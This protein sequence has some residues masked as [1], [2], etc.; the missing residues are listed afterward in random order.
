MKERILKYLDEFSRGVE[1]DLAEELMQEL[2]LDENTFRERSHRVQLEILHN[3]NQFSI[4]TIDAFFQRVIRSFTREAGLA[5]DYRLEV[6]QDDVLTAVINNLIDELENNKGLTRW[7]V[8]F[9]GENLA[10]DMPW[11]VRQSLKD[12]AAELL[13]EEFKRIENDLVNA[14][15]NPGF[16]VALRNELSARKFAFIGFVRK[17]AGEVMQKFNEAGL[18]IN[19]FKFGKSGSVYGWFNKLAEIKKVKDFVEKELGKRPL[20]EFQSVSNWYSKD[21][22][23]KTVITQLA[24]GGALQAMNEIIEY[25]QRNFTQS[26]SA[27]VV[28]N[29][30][31]VFGLTAD[32]AGKLKEYNK[33]NNV[34]LLA[35]AP[36]FLNGVIDHSD[37]PFI[38]EKIGSFYKNFLIDEF[39]DTSGLQWANL[40]PLIINSLDQGNRSLV[41]GDVKQAIYRWRGGDLGLLQKEI[42]HHT[43]TGRTEIKN[44]DT[45]FRSAKSLVSFNNA[46]FKTAAEVVAKEV[47]AS[48]V[49]E[50][51]HD[52]AQQPYQQEEGFIRIQFIPNEKDEKWERTALNNLCVTVETLQQ[53]GVAPRDIAILVRRNEEGQRIVAHLLQYKNSPSARPDTRYEVIS[54]ESLRIDG[55]ASVNLLLAA[56]RYLDNP[57][58]VIARAQLAYE[59]ARVT[60]DQKPLTETLMVT[61]H[62][63]FESYLPQAF[64]RSKISLLKLP[65]FELT[66]TLIHIFKLDSQTG[67]LPYLNAFQDCVLQFAARE[68]ND[69]GAFLTWWEENRDSEKTSLKSSGDADAI[70]IFSIHKAKGLQFKYVIIPFCSWSLDHA[71]PPTLWVKSDKDIF[72]EAGTFPVRY[73]SVLEET[74]FDLYYQA[75]RASCY[76]DN[77]NLLYVAFTRAELGLFVTAPAPGKSKKDGEFTKNAGGLLYQ[78]I[79]LNDDLKINWDASG[80]CWQKGILVPASA[81]AAEQ[82][83]HNFALRYYPV[84]VWRDKLVVRQ[85]GLHFFGAA[86]AERITRIEYGIHLHALLSEMKYADELENAITKL[87]DNGLMTRD[88]EAGVRQQ[89]ES[90]FK[91]PLIA[92]WFDPR[93]EVRTEVP[94]LVPGEGEIRMD[95]LMI[96]DNQAVI[97]DFKTGNPAKADQNQVLNY[98]NTLR[99]MGFANVGGYLVYTATGDVVDVKPGKVKTRKGKDSSHQLELGLDY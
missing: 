58:N 66:E 40:R 48:V 49:T 41:V 72:K 99:N 77:L 76:L 33:E 10:N 60:D 35:D 69:I 42:E 26:L 7:V 36:K 8:D 25:R 11:D 46:L 83:E 32:V 37:T 93:W 51:F 38:Y 5:G 15:G 56:L 39:Q 81:P 21:T 80:N 98:M 2:K 62:S 64:V 61:N 53:H 68:R 16:F 34:L 27:E 47:S 52:V 31:Y 13:K 24:E 57:D 12:F 82:T 28:L 18:D 19:D 55:A 17:K 94:V 75:E 71:N 90:L 23:K 45:N 43:G 95:R 20:N 63:V 29:Y 50:A 92:S 4:S 67:E 89:V 22:V 54:N 1:N 9:A 73:G 91:N 74:Y 70:R 14:T 85:T 97:V 44:L 59:F 86:A 79:Q 65:L 96:R 87:I 78:S 88:E 30:F 84:N 3:Y 6:D